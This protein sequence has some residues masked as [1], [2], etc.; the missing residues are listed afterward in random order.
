MLLNEIRYPVTFLSTPHLIIIFIFLPVAIFLAFFLSKKYGFSK[1]IIWIV[2]IAGMLCEI[3]RLIFFMEETEGGFRLPPDFLPFN[4][5]QFQVILMFILAFSEDIQKHKLLL[6]FMYPTLVGVAFMGSMIPAAATYHG[7][8]ELSTYRYF[9]FHAMLM[10]FGLYLYLSRPIQYSLKNYFAGIFF[11]FSSMAFAVWLNAFFGWDP[12]VNH[13]F[14]VRPPIEGL[15]ILN[16]NN[17]W[18][19]Y[20][21]DMTWVGFTL[22]TL[23]YL[24][25]II[26]ETP[27]Q[28]RQIIK[29][30]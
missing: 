27:K 30:R 12:S 14:V 5:C 19:N 18:L 1:K 2:A 10:F 29:N 16:L 4:L 22:I 17:G 15:P 13:M 11:T 28:I 21:F 7:L 20:M 9:F 25:V 8:L 6:S 3:E 24:P 26:R 23:C